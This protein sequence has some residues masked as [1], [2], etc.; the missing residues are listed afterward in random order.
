MGHHAEMIDFFLP[1]LNTQRLAGILHY[2]LALA[3]L[4]IALVLSLAYTLALA[5]LV[6]ALVLSLDAS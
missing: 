2:T 6:I 3:V 5:V 4:V 1:F